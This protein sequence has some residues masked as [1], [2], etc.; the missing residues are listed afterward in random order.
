MRNQFGSHRL[1]RELLLLIAL[2]SLL[3]VAIYCAFF[4]PSHRVQLDGAGV[5]QWL[6]SPT[7]SGTTR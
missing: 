3:L 4:S 6:L 1:A 5:A 7:T 2:K